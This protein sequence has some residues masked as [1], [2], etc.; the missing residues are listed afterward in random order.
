MAYH[1]DNGIMLAV[2]YTVDI[3]TTF[4]EQMCNRLFI[5]I[6]ELVHYMPEFQNA[7]GSYYSVRTSMTRSNGSKRFMYQCYGKGF[8]KQNLDDY[9]V[10]AL[11]SAIYFYNNVNKT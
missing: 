6:H 9:R 7:T 4:V 8:R 11:C 3:S 1:A 10:V 5:N 2:G